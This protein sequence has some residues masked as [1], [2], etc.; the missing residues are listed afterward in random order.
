MSEHLKNIEAETVLDV[1]EKHLTGCRVDFKHLYDLAWVQIQILDEALEFI[2]DWKEAQ[3]D[4]KEG[5]K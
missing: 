1:V 2:K 4:D 5:L 3:E